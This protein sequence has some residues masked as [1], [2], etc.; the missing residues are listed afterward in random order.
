MYY[1]I[2]PYAYVANNPIIFIDPDGMRLDWVHD[3]ENDKYVWM[4]NVA[5]PEST[6]E[7]YRYVG[8]KDSDILTDLNLPNSLSTEEAIRIGFSL[9]GEG[10]GAAPVGTMAKA[11]GNLSI[12][13]D[14]SINKENASENNAMGKKFEGITITT[15]FSYSSKS[16]ISDLKLSYNRFLYVKHGENQYSSMLSPS[17]GNVLY[18]AGTVPMN[19]SISVSEKD[20][21]RQ[22]P[23]Y[24]AGIIAGAPNSKVVI[25]PRPIKMEWNL[26]RNPIYLPK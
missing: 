14:V 8:S 7:G 12:K 25:S 2:S 6:P 16:P 1:P 26:Q 13:A 10:K 11:S 23:F 5:S 4:D 3:K 24:A 22:K 18:E 15:N 20:I 9:E 17:S 21:S 19:A